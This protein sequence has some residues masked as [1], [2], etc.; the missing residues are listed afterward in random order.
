MTE[1][2]ATAGIVA[3][4]G[5]PGFEPPMVT[6]IVRAASFERNPVEEECGAICMFGFG[7]NTKGQRGRHGCRCIAPASAGGIKKKPTLPG[8]VCIVTGILPVSVEGKDTFTCS[9][10]GCGISVLNSVDVSREVTSFDPP[11]QDVEQQ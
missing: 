9:K 1:P 8:I 2:A 5:P 10:A 3:P 6:S 4:S 7:C 11:V